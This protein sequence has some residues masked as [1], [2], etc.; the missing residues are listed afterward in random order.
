MTKS[1]HHHHDHPDGHEHS[2]QHTYPC[3]KRILTIRLHS[4][5]AGDMFVCGLLSMLDLSDEEANQILRGILPSLEGTLKRVD[6]Y[7]G[8][9]RGSYCEID[10]PKEHTHRNLADIQKI[11]EQSEISDKAKKFADKAFCFVALAESKVHGKP[12]EEVHF[13]EVGALDSILDTLFTCELFTQL[14]I[15]ELVVS[16][17]PLADGEIRCAHGVIPCPAPAVKALLDGI[18]VRPFEANGET[19]TPTAIALLKALGAKFGPWPEMTIEK[20]ETVYGSYV[21]EGVPNGATFA[22]GRSY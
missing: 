8:H 6:K 15:D 11:I 5:I 1:E 4:G 22:L 2:A 13:H 3:D 17:L 19:I 7:I 9:I 14:K 21:Y 10:L 12:V 18:P 20:I 16:P